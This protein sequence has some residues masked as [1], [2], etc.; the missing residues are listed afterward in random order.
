LMR[1]FYLGTN[2]RKNY[3]DTHLWVK[4][5]KWKIIDWCDNNNFVLNC[6]SLWV[7]A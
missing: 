7:Y 1:N 5:I 3:L 6:N 2:P 4:K